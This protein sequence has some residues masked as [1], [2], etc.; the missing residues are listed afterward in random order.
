M[1]EFSAA[2]AAVHC[3][4]HQ[5]G[6]HLT[7]RDL[8]TSVMKRLPH[9]VPPLTA[10]FKPRGEELMLFKLFDFDFVDPQ[11]VTW[12]SNTDLISKFRN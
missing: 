10:W 5:S 11:L 12:H 1:I 2:A 4:W 8:F 3:L 7:V 6:F 9:C